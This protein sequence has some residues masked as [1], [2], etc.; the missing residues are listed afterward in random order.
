MNVGRGREGGIAHS[1]L[2]L[3]THLPPLFSL[4]DA[5]TAIQWYKFRDERIPSRVFRHAVPFKLH[6]RREGILQ[7]R[8][9]TYNMVTD[10]AFCLGYLRGGHIQISSISTNR[11]CQSRFD[12]RYLFPF[13]NS[14]TCSCY[15]DWTGNEC[16]KPVCPD[17]C[18]ENL[19]LGQCSTLEYKCKCNSGVIG[20]S[21]ALKLDS[22]ESNMREVFWSWFFIFC[23]PGSS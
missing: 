8:V 9:S 21:C 10:S 15:G 4:A 7:A 14:G 13:F 19:H 16:S 3:I 20:E 5:H 2:Q 17:D 6:I 1:R 22:S 12:T 23:L 18:H 11:F